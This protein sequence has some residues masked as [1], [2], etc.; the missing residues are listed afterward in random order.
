MNTT[1]TY[2]TQLS[3]KNGA[4]SGYKMAAILG[5]SKQS[6]SRYQNGHK[7]MNDATSTKMAA[8]LGI[9]PLIVYAEIQLESAKSREARHLWGR[10]LDLTKS[11]TALAIIGFALV[12]PMANQA[13][14]M[15]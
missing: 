5:V 7:Q 13:L 2:L 11:S 15:S 3:V 12:L 10:I 6:V 9:D 1:Q 8:E 4:A 14:N